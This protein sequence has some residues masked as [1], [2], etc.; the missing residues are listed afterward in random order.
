MDCTSIIISLAQIIDSN[1]NALK[2]IFY[3][4]QFALLTHVYFIN[5][6]KQEQCTY[7]NK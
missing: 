6:Y 3:T 5:T 4:S 1:T 2:M 7:S